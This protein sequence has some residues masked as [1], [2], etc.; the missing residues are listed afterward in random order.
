M[1]FVVD[2]C[3]LCGKIIPSIHRKLCDKRKMKERFFDMLEKP[4]KLSEN[5]TTVLTYVISDLFLVKF[6]VVV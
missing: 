4:F 5:K 3:L 6:F 2:F 1:Y